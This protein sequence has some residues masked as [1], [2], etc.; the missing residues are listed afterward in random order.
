MPVM[1]RR[2][3]HY[4]VSFATANIHSL[5]FK[6]DGHA[7]KLSYLQEQ[8]RLFRLNC[9]GIQEAR[10]EQG[11]ACRSNILRFSSGHHQGHLGVELWFDLD[12]PICLDTHGKP[13]YAKRADF[14]VVHADPRRLLVKMDN[15][16]WNVWLLVLH[17]PHS[18]KSQQDREEWW[19]DTQQILQQSKDDGPLVALMD[20]NAPP[21]E[22]D[23]TIVLQTGSHTAVSTQLLRQFLSENQ[24]C[25]PATGPAHVGDHGTWTDFQGQHAHAIDHIAI[26][27]TWLSHCTHSQVLDDF[28]LATAHED[29]KAIALQLTWSDVIDEWVQRPKTQGRLAIDYRHP[30]LTQ[31]LCQYQPADWH[32]DVETH[33]DVL[34]AFIHN[35]MQQSAV[36]QDQHLL[37]KKHYLTA[38]IWALRKSKLKQRATLKELRKRITIEVL[39]GC[40]ESWRAHQQEIPAWTNRACPWLYRD[41]LQCHQL[42]YWISYRRIAQKLKRD[43]S[44]SKQKSLHQ[45]LQEFDCHTAASDIIKEL[46]PF[47]GPT[48]P[49][50]LKKKTLPLVCAADGSVCQHPS[51]ALGTWI[52]YFMQMEGGSRISRAELRQKWIKDLAHFANPSIH[53]AIEELPSLVDLELSFRRVPCG[54]ARGPDH[55]PG[56]ICHH[57]PAPLA[58]ACYSQLAK[59]ICHGQEYLGH[60]GGI[61]T[62]AY[63]GKG[64]TNQCSSYRSLLVSSHIGKVLHRTIRQTSA[65]LYEAFLQGQQVGGRRKVP[66]QLALHQVRAHMRQ[67][68]ASHRS[69]GVLFLDL[70]EAFYRILREIP[71]GGQPTDET[72]A[73]VVSRLGLPT[74]AL[75]DIHALLQEPSALHQA[76]LSATA[77]NCIAAIHQ[78]T[79][80]WMEGQSDVALTTMGTRPGDCFA[81]VVFGFAWGVIL[82]KMENFMLAN[83]LVDPMPAASQPSFFN[84]AAQPTPNGADDYVFI[85]PTWMDDL[86]LCVDATTPRQLEQ[87]IGQAASHL[88]DLC[89]QHMMSPNLAAGKTEMLLVFRGCKSRQFKEKYYGMSSSGSFPI[90]TE[91]SAKSIRV[92]KQYRHLGGWL[93]HRNDQRSDMAQKGA[94]A[95]EAFNVHRR[96][97]YGNIAIELT[98]RGELFS[99]LVLTKLLYGADSWTLDTQRDRKK[100]HSTVFKLYRRLLKWRPD[101]GHSDAEVL[102]RLEMLSPEELLRR[103]RLRYLVVLLNCGLPDI[104]SL[105]N[106]DIKWCQAIEQDLVWM[107]IQLRNS[108]SLL[109]PREHFPQ[110]LLLMQDHRSYWKKLVNRACLHAV[111][112]RKKTFEV[113]ALHARALTRFQQ[114]WGL[115]SDVCEPPLEPADD[116]VRSFGCVT[117]RKKCRN[118]A[119]E[120]AHMFKAHRR[121]ARSRLLFDEPSCPACLRFFHTMA[122]M[123]AHLYYAPQCR[124]QL[125]NR[126]MICQASDGTGSRADKVRENVHDFLLPPAQGFGP[127]LPDVKAREHHFIDEEL[128]LFLVEQIDERVPIEDLEQ[129]LMNFAA[130]HPISWT[131]WT[132]TLL[133]F[134]DSFGIEEANFFQYDLNVLRELFQR[135]CDANAWSFLQT[136]QSEGMDQKNNTIDEWHASC[137]SLALGPGQ[138]QLWTVPRQ[139]GRHRCVLHAF[140][141]RRRVGDLQYFLER[142]LAQHEQ[143]FVIHIISLDVIVDGT[144]GNAADPHIR[145]FWLDAIKSKWVIAFLGGPPCETWSR[146]RAVGHG[147]KGRFM[148]RVLRDSALPWGF[149]SVSIRELHQILLGNLLLGFAVEAMIEIA[150]VNALGVLEHPAE[151]DDLDDAASI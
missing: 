42:K 25:L 77:R 121:I 20:A 63:K 141:G 12:L 39:R 92:V 71:I 143:T 88:L 66:V 114:V 131:V 134:M 30:A 84:A 122:K 120:G 150:A 43:I 137:A 119:G 70:T 151:P 74:S 52:D 24:L 31:G 17:A 28:D 124:D 139:F 127:R 87:R 125:L 41:V 102:S 44:L 90:L 136:A 98:K 11:V 54:R 129:C 86:A 26:P 29:H 105:F 132:R 49:K 73:H 110:W 34:N 89:E 75:H 48:N 67:A 10:T 35:A 103:A 7:G 109:D 8:M 85:G 104:W 55:I 16:L 50:K 2:H 126:N 130:D 1:K 33:T 113:C 6:P 59:M 106:R 79:F 91:R 5:S 46:R 15:P 97:L 56:E 3:L 117:C 4:M 76:G 57:Q 144:W 123:K 37:A 69:A 22:V 99:T 60:K 36:Q 146:V 149:E 101:Q 14:Q 51:D 142:E 145:R 95:H 13:R 111:L 53:I 93:H 94:L 9:L 115:T 19:N 133:F 27:Q 21:G 80:F 107:W 148:P 83:G 72:L 82:H 81:D 147:A 118:L 135:L 100:F 64:R 40:F 62:A 78:G 61:L 47:L 108:S 140:S 65:A 128:H 116:L 45:K 138:S 32:T 112:Q 38:E 58:L 18:G 96:V 68:H 23:G